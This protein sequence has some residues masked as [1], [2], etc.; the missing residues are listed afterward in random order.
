ML[1]N[2]I[3]EIFIVLTIT[4]LLTG[5]IAADGT[6]DP[7]HQIVKQLKWF[8]QSAF[9]LETAGK[10]I[11][12]DPFRI[13]VK[14]EADVVFITHSHQDHF[15]KT[16]L[17]KILTPQTVIVAP[18]SCKSELRSFNNEQILLSPGDTG[19]V[20]GFPVQAVP[21]Y[22]R[23]KTKYHPRKKN[24]LGYVVTIDGVRLYH[25]GDTERIPEM[26]DFRC[27]IALLP[28]GQTYTM[29]SVEEA[30][31]AARDVQARVVVPMHYGFYE[32]KV[33][34]VETLRQLLK[35]EIE[36]IR[37]KGNFE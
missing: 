26:Q 7:L 19:T 14:D 23:V 3:G 17:Q 18:A 6:D 15:S 9:R 27:D 12:F 10:V 13:D 8:A 36:V 2:E 16:D 29:N 5:L 33:K 25:A 20:A 22:N 1:R 34:D 30:A 28:L 35:G 32:G 21:M 24:W 4:T 31:Q 11:Y 37:L